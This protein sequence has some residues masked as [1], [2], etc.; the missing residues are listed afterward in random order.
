MG[1]FL[2]FL[3]QGIVGL[4]APDAFSCEPRAIRLALICYA[5]THNVCNKETHYK[6][7]IVPNKNKTK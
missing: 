3:Y 5:L 4:K 6:K 1:P 2:C 7:S